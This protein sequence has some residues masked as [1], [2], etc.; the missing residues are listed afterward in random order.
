[1]N[2]PSAAVESFDFIINRR[3]GAVLKAGEDKVRAEIL[4]R[5]GARGGTFC[6]SRGQRYCGNR[7]GLGC[8]NMPE[9]IA[10]W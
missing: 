2:M 5:F 3:G 4:A 9:K 7:E 10:A 1:M 8:R 6:Y